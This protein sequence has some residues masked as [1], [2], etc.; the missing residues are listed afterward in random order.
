MRT[1]K[2]FCHQ[3]L[4][5]QMNGQTDSTLVETV[6]Y[7]MAGVSTGSLGSMEPVNFQKSIF[8]PVIFGKK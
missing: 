3:S 4:N 2:T 8:E 1:M 5:G 7:I 6:M